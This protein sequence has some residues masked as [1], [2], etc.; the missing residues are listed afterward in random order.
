[1]L[2]LEQ[3]QATTAPTTAPRTTDQEA[4]T[5]P[6]EVNEAALAGVEA[7]RDRGTGQEPL[8]ATEGAERG[9]KGGFFRRTIA[10]LTQPTTTR[11]VATAEPAATH[12]TL[13]ERL[14]RR[15]TNLPARG[16]GTTGTPATEG[17]EEVEFPTFVSTNEDTTSER[18]KRVIVTALGNGGFLTRAV[19]P[20]FTVGRSNVAPEVET[21]LPAAVRARAVNTTIVRTPVLTPA[22][23]R[24]TILLVILDV[25]VRVVVFLL[26]PRRT[27]DGMRGVETTRPGAP[28]TTPGEA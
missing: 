25:L 26:L 13:A 24:S 4:T 10:G 8:E 1:M 14:Q 27:Q 17:G 9:G 20:L 28:R 21:T 22:M 16:A 12:G 15:V 5:T 6:E 19:F 2:V 23:I 18:A 11:E 7:A 3:L